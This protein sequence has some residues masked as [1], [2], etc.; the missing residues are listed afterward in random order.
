MT[1]SEHTGVLG[2][3]LVDDHLKIVEG[4]KHQS[5]FQITEAASGRTRYSFNFE[6]FADKNMTRRFAEDITRL[7]ESHKFAC[8]EV[9]FSLDSRM[10][11]VKKIPIDRELAPAEV[12]QQVNWEV[13]QFTISPVDEYIVDYERLFSQGP[14]GA[15]DYI[16]V[17]TVRKQIVDYVRRIFRHTDLR[18]KV[19]DVD[20]FSAQRALQLNY[21]CG[22]HDRIAL[23]D[24]STTKVNL[25]ILE[26]KTY[27]L[28]QEFGL[29]QNSLD[30]D[31]RKD[32]A[33]RLI[34]KEL[35]R[36]ML[37]YQLGKSV[38]DLNELYLYGEGVDDGLLE[39]LQNTYN[40]RIDRA[41]P[42]RR[43]KLPSELKAEYGEKRPERFMVAV[44]VAIRGV[45]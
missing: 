34:S 27:F 37:D 22:E 8:K 17:V 43:V 29:P 15:E 14:T 19:V 21:D 3:S 9:A 1:P 16:L 12:E 23:V 32:T 36:L 20:I 28:S 10:V 18:L 2:V 33:T 25:A 7:Y 45:Q 26:G 11:L 31:S 40:V 39:T 6:S 13:R 5:E 44:G 38:E 4:Q 35:R 42:F 24:V 30:A 41:N